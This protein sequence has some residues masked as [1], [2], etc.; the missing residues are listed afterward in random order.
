V[1]GMFAHAALAY[2]PY[3]AL[4]TEAG[5]LRSRAI[6]AYDRFAGSSTRQTACDDGTVKYGDADRTAAEQDNLQTVAAIYLY[7]LTGEARFHDRVKSAYRNLRP[8]RDSGWNRYESEQG[9]ALLFY[10]RLAN[11]DA[12]LKATILADK[13]N[14]ADPS[15]N[16]VYGLQTNLD[17][18]RS[19]LHPDQYHWGSHQVRANYGNSNQDVLSYGIAVASTVPYATRAEDTLHYFHG[20]NPF[21]MVYL[22]NV[23]AL[24]TTRSLSTIY[25]QAWFKDGNALWDDL[26]SSSCGPA[27]GYVPGG[28]NASAQANGVPAYLAPP[29]QQ[30]RQKAYFEWNNPNE[31][32]YAVTEPA[33]YYQSAYVK[34]VSAFVRP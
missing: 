17:P 14:D 28:P 13:R 8:Y 27:P 10:T 7:A 16:Q 2:Q 15:W 6:A 32:A 30:P 5:D 21:G 3:P 23:N 34:L 18:Y 29:T 20:V 31:A 19:Y 12:T 22:S 26:R 25:H 33:I 24:G 9:S 1:A 4:A 11:A